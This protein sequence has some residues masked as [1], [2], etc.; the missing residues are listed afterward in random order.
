MKVVA[1]CEVSSFSA[2]ASPL[3]DQHLRLDLSRQ[4]SAT[5]KLLILR[6][7]QHFFTTISTASDNR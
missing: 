2:C 6:P 3:S 7:T 4:S 1:T 5:Q